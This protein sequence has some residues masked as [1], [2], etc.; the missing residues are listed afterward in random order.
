M[1]RAKKTW[2]PVVEHDGE[3]YIHMHGS[4]YMHVPKGQ[5]DDEV[6]AGL[7]KLAEDHEDFKAGRP[8]RHGSTFRKTRRGTR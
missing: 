7:V 6:R 3:R 2:E 8:T 1:T 5:T 4:H